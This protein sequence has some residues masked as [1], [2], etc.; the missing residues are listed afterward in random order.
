MKRQQGFT[1]IELIA[2]IVILGILAAVAIPRFV[3]L[4]DAANEAAVKG[5]AGG[6]ASASALNHAANIAADAGLTN[7]PTPTNVAN[8]TD[9]ANLMD[10]SY[11][12]STYPIT[13]QAI[14]DG[15]TVTCEVTD[16]SGT[17]PA[18]FTGHGVA[19]P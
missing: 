6:L 18:F 12:A 1:L 3:N 14:A 17:F 15:A 9:V 13:A 16:I 11:D 2:V 4:Q 19:V 7:A 8:C 5:V 10:S